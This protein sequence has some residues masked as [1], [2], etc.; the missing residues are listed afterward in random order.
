MSYLEKTARK[1]LPILI[2]VKNKMIPEKKL[3]EKSE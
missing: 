1:I 2:E 3:N